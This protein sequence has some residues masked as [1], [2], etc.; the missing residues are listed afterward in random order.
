MLI[1]GKDYLIRKRQVFDDL[2]VDQIN[3]YEQ[4]ILKV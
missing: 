2:L 1:D 3:I 4:K